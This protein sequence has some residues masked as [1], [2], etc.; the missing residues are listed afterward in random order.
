MSIIVDK[1]K[2]IYYKKCEENLRKILK[3]LQSKEF[4][5]YYEPICSHK[6]TIDIWDYHV[7]DI[8]N[9]ANI[10]KIKQGENK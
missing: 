10:V 4:L 3:I 5:D 1:D 2:Y 6:D 8:Y 9:N 7:I